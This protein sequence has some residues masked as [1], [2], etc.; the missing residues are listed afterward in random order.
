MSRTT[1]EKTR[2]AERIYLVSYDISDNKC[3]TKIA[4][5]MEGFGKRVQYSVFECTHLPPKQYERMVK[6]L[7][8]LMEGQEEGS[9]RIYY[10]CGSCQA[11]RFIIGE[12][13]QDKIEDPLSSND[14]VLYV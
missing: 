3:R 6:K 13:P 12:E 8:E 7:T 4:K 9:I 5:T 2:E 11:K 10:I 14:A 1:G